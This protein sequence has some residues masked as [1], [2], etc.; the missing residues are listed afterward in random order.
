MILCARILTCFLV[1]SGIVLRAQIA[2][3]M[4]DLYG[5]NTGHTVCNF[6]TLPVSVGDLGRGLSASPGMMDATVLPNFTATSSYFESYKFAVSHI[7]WLQGL[8]KEYAGAC[9][10]VFGVGTIGGF[11]RLFTAGK[12]PNS[13]DIDE[14]PAKPR[15][16]EYALGLSFAR[17]IVY[18]TLAAGATFSYIDSRLDTE[19]G[20]TV[21]GHIDCALDLP[22][23]KAR[24]YGGNFG[25]DL[26]YIAT[27][28]P[29]PVQT[30]ASVFVMP[31]AHSLA[32]KNK[33]SIEAGAGVQ[34]SA[35]EPLLIGFSS[36]VGIL[37]WIKVRGGYEFP[38]GIKNSIVGLSLGAGF[39][40]K[41]F[42]ADFGWKYQSEEL[43][44]VW[45]ISAKMHLEE[46][47]PKTAEDFYKVAAGHFT[48]ERY[49]L[50][51]RYAREA[52][53]LNPEMWKAH[54][55]I[56]RA[57]SELRQ[58]EGKEIALIYAGNAQGM[59]LPFLSENE[60][61]GGIA[62]QVSAIKTLQSSYPA[63]VQINTGNNILKISHELK[64]QLFDEYYQSISWDAVALGTGEINYGF[65]KYLS[66]TNKSG[67][68]FICTNAGDEFGRSVVRMKYIDVSRYKLL[69]LNVVN[70]S[71]SASTHDTALFSAA[72]GQ[73]ESELSYA[74]S[75]ECNLGICIVNDT[76][77]NTLRY[78]TAV[79][80]IDV[81]IC[82][83]LKREFHTPMRAGSSIILS[84]GD[85]SR[86]IG[87]LTIRFD[88]NGEMLSYDNKLIP[89]TSNVVPDPAMDELARTIS[90]Q[91]EL[92]KQDIFIEDLARGSVDGTLLF[93]SDRHGERG[94]FLKVI[95]KLAEFPLTPRTRACHTPVFSYKCG[96][97]AYLSD[98]ETTGNSSLFSMSFSGMDVVELCSD[99]HVEDHCFGPAGKWLY[100]SA[101]ARPG[102]STTIFRIE[103][104][105]G[106]RQPVV[107]WK[108]SRE[109]D[110][111]IS[112]DGTLLAFVTNRDKLR[113]IYISSSSGEK[114]LRITN[115]KA[116]HAKPSFAP[117]G[118]SVAFLSDRMS[119]RDRM[120]LFIHTMSTG[121]TIPLT[122]QANV[123]DYCWLDDSKRIV[124]SAGVNLCDLTI[125]SIETGASSKLVVDN[126]IQ[127]YSELAPR[128]M[129]YKGKEE[130]I[131]YREHE[132]GDRQ[133]Y[134]VYPDG[135]E[136]T[137][138]V[139]SPGRDWI[140]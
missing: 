31:L 56:A 108:N 32:L 5:E 50:C 21:A 107:A 92:E 62:R 98:N 20:R 130:I 139:N 52:V 128:T 13:R 113:Q 16:L 135:T 89:L 84:A 102:E 78:A 34:K 23:V 4:T 8:R 126:Q 30:G 117:D 90:I 15:Y 14:R 42:G 63:T 88:N 73:L 39:H 68:K 100:F 133:I 65:A 76:Y 70:P 115:A 134:R 122:R 37:E 44:G 119:T 121:K 86:F 3:W 28:E 105:G 53:R 131:Y 38:L 69:I 101:A 112:P 48:R 82:S 120:D 29:L 26:T 46:I 93:M 43:G 19:S 75:Q 72:V 138:I 6:L 22:F 140:E 136:N 111:A 85:S 64:A 114:P 96:K 124:Y 58:A 116:S 61:I 87:N 9:F 123:S 10:P 2:D 24:L 79:P 104:S 97:A 7:E 91:I 51:I 81:F 60:Y 33:V 25:P 80:Q 71:R 77:Q 36:E 125:I 27:P 66:E 45:G 95:D 54:T 57:K 41:N 99:L 49:N 129:I 47:L 12:F 35:D 132:N 40:V 103:P 55:L 17:E 1:C 94:V 109:H 83:G 110:M 106:V 127:N 74:E 18:R 11:S 67:T 118:N 59:V 137:C